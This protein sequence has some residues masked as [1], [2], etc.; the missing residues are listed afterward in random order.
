MAWSVTEFPLGS[1]RLLVLQADSKLELDSLIA[2]AT[3][4]GWQPYVD[5]TV[6]DTSELGAWMLKAIEELQSSNS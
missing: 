4:K 2:K 1:N 3:L 6:P 5:G